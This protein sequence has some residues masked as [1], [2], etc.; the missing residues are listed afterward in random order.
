MGTRKCF[1][2]SGFN[3]LERLK[4]GPCSAPVSGQC[5]SLR[6]DNYEAPFMSMKLACR[7]IDSH[8]IASLFLRRQSPLNLC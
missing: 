2:S 3:V 5:R 8:H 4:G 6:C 1:D 7:Y